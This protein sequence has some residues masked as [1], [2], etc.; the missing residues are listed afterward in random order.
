MLS[1]KD[2]CTE[3][4]GSHRRKYHRGKSW[5][6]CYGF[7]KDYK[8]FRA[9]KKLLDH[10]ALHLGFFLASWGMLRGSSFLLNVDYKYYTRIVRLLIKPR[11]DKLWNVDYS[12][13]AGGGELLKLLFGLVDKLRKE[14]KEMNGSNDKGRKGPSD[15]LVTKILMATMG[16]VPAYDR[17]FKRGLRRFLEQRHM[18]SKVKFNREAFGEL[19][20]LTREDKILRKIYRVRTITILKGILYPPMKLLDLYFWEMGRNNGKVLP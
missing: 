9:N 11:Y 18:K 20:Q 17:F 3:I 16:C 19:L 14:M 12:N 4:K 5:E 6:Y 1:I 15:T 2:I 13:A 10:A 7:F 8:N